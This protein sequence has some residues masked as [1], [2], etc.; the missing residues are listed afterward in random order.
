MIATP[1]T[2][3]PGEP[4]TAVSAVATT[5]PNVVRTSRS[6]IRLRRNGSRSPGR[7]CEYSRIPRFVSP[8]SVKPPMMNTIAETA[9]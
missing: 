4:V 3:I 7:S 1:P 6:P 5:T 9:T 2:T 8:A